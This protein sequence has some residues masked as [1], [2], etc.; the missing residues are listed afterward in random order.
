M[1]P[2]EAALQLALCHEIG[3]GV[4]RDIKSARRIH[5]SYSHSLSDLERLVDSIKSSKRKFQLRRGFTSQLLSNGYISRIDFPHNYRD[6]SLLLRAEEVYRRE[7]QDIQAALGKAHW[8]KVELKSILEDLL[9]SQG[10]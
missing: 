3:F 9:S 7:I 2:A 1:S 4:T 5:T 8:L 10:R 6:N